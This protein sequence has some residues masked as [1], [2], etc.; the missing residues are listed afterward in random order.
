[1]NAATP[2][3]LAEAFDHP[4]R[5]ADLPLTG[6]IVLLAQAA[7]VTARATAALAVKNDAPQPT[8]TTPELITVAEAMKITG[9]TARWFYSRAGRKQ[10]RFIKKL[11]PRTVRVDKAAFA[12]WL[13]AQ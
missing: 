5:V 13:A 10:F 4:D 12:Q 9:M 3:T 6:L 8:P 1:V 11:S 2:P 7:T